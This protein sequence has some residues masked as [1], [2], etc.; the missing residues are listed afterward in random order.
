MIRK[1]IAEVEDRHRGSLFHWSRPGIWN[2]VSQN[3]ICTFTTRLM[4]I[5]W[6]ISL[7]SIT[8]IIKII[9]NLF[10]SMSSLREFSIFAQKLE[11]FQALDYCILP[12]GVHSIS[13]HPSVRME[14]A[15]QYPVLCTTWTP[16]IFY[17]PSLE[18]FKTWVRKAR[19]S[20]AD[21]VVDT[22]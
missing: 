18:V 20:W 14:E 7:S 12:L 10:L 16:V 5:L 21:L 15:Y 11:M 3:S 13:D 19:R 6:W 4:A 2:S 9:K 17:S 1:L 8:H 22:A